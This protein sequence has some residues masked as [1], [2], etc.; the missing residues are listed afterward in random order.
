MIVADLVRVAI[1]LNEAEADLI[2]QILDEEGIKSLVQRSQD[3]DVP[4]ML[5]GGK[6]QVMVRADQADAARDVL[7]QLEEM[8]PDPD[9]GLYREQNRDQ[10][11]WIG[12]ILLA[13]ILLAL[14]SQLI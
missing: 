12:L 9:L 1:C 14:L 11:K 13:I 4:E 8:H 6:R 10:L 2:G 3:M 5:A 7:N